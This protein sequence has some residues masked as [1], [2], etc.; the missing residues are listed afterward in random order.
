LRAAGSEPWLVYQLDRGGVL[1]RGV[2]VFIEFEP[3]S[4]CFFFFELNE[5][6]SALE[7]TGEIVTVIFC[8]Y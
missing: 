1:N 6:L 7:I 5:H 2:G 4:S 8:R 3:T